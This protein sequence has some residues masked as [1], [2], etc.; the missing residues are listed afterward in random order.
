MPRLLPFL[1]LALFAGAARADNVSDLLAKIQAVGREG[2]GNAE[3]SRA[4]RALTRQG[5]EA[6]PRVLAAMDGAGPVATN[7]LRGAAEALAEQVRR[8]G[9]KL[10]ADRLEAFVRDTKHS[11]RARRVAYELLTRVDPDTPR[12]LLPTLLDDPGQELRRDAV[13]VLLDT[14]QKLHDAKDAGARAAYQKALRHARD[15]DQVK[16]VAQRLADLG[17]PVDLVQHFGYLTRWHVIGPFD[18]AGGAGFAKPYPPEKGIDLKATYVGKDGKEV[19]WQ[20]CVTPAPK[21]PT[22]PNSLAL[23]DFNKR[24]AALKGVVGYA[25]A[26]VYS[27][28]EQPVELRAASNNAVRLYLNGKEVYFREEYHHGMEMDQHAGR[29]TLRPGRNVILVKVCQNE[30]TESWAR[31]WSFQLRVCDALGGAVPLRT[32]KNG[33]AER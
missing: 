5:P 10:P 23:V 16:L 3:A 29:G 20:E 26:E 32:G 9:K 2:M 24:L 7:W 33:A 18:N 4:V 31:L 1:A 11:G 27:E 15:R 22:D 30:Q 19:R 8:D 25:C 14:A 6:L 21:N 28:R 13:A 12:R 17:A